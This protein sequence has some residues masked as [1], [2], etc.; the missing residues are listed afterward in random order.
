MVFL[1]P[2]PLMIDCYI[3]RV[4]PK[5]PSIGLQS[6]ELLSNQVS[7]LKFCRWDNSH[8]LSLPRGVGRF[9]AEMISI[10]KFL[11]IG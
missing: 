11:I 5:S 7:H 6:P 2:T 9:I 4:P 8:S 10:D 3:S 1:P